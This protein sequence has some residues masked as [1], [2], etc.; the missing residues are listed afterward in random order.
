MRYYVGVT[1]N[2]WFSY[3]AQIKPDEVNFWRPSGK[4]FKALEIGAPF[5]FKLHSPLNY[6]VGGGFFVRS[7]Q[8]PLSL[9]WEAFGDKNGASSY[10][11]LLRLI[12][13]RRRD[14]H[15]DPE[16]GCIILNE[17]FFFRRDS[18][19]PAPANWKPN[20][21]TGK[22]YSTNTAIGR[23]I[24][25]QVSQNLA[26]LRGELIPSQVEDTEARLGS[27][28]LRRSRLGQGAF[29]ILVTDAYGRR[30]SISGEKALPVLQAAHIKPFADEGPNH[31]NNGLLLRSDMHILFD[32]G[33]IT[34]TPDYR[35]EVSRRIK[36]EFDNGEHYYSHHGQPLIVLPQ[37]P[38]DQPNHDFLNWHNSHV[39]RG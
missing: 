7:E 18:W 15:P 31:V 33:Y 17:P 16:I 9:S 28:Y 19:I 23:S 14:D 11:D 25:T 29:R 1:D 36:E 34:V 22:G 2:E 10:L 37:A 35:V 27:E 32:R 6:I 24:W 13:G 38:L 20:I 21:V 30:C 5:L 3:L 12:Q 4:G 39:Y 26:S 8:L